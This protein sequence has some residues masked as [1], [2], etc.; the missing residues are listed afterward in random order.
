MLNLYHK[1]VSVLTKKGLPPRQ[2]H[3]PPYEYATLI[4]EQIPGGREAVAWLTE[5]ASSAAYDPRPFNPS[6]VLEAK[7]RLSALRQTLA[8]RR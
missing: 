8:G 2:P 3:Q 4:Y 7:R 5:A 1:M 6:H